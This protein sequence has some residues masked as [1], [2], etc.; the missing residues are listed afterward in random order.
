MTIGHCSAPL[1]LISP[2]LRTL[3]HCRKN[4]LDTLRDSLP[5]IST[6]KIMSNY[7]SMSERNS[8]GKSTDENTETDYTQIASYTD[9]NTDGVQEETSTPLSKRKNN[10]KS[11]IVAWWQKL[12][13]R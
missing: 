11:R 10:L 3:T 2:K 8:A 13:G 7:T 6:S 4:C 5:P 1:S 12:F 9:K